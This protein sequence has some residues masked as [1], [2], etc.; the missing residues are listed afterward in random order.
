MARTTSTSTLVL[1]L[2]G[3]LLAG[4]LLFAGGGMMAGGPMGGHGPMVGDGGMWA[5]GMTDGA[6]GW[7]LPVAFGTRLVVLAVIVGAIYLA[8]RRVTGTEDTDPAMG[9]LRRA[10]A[11]GDLT[12]EEFDERRERP[13]HARVPN[14]AER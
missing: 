2:L 8:Y 1:V 12:E 13:E 10:Y 9:E 14:D 3:L 11:R 4:P 7:W 6:A 5:S